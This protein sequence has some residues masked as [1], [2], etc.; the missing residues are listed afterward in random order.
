MADIGKLL[1]K[2]APRDI[3]IITEEIIELKQTAGAAVLGIGQR[4]NEAK[5]VLNHGEWLPWLTEKVEFSERSA[6]TFMRLAREWSNPQA[7]ADLGKSKALTLLALP[8][9]E[10]EQFIAEP[11]LVDGTVKN[12][13]DMTSRELEKAIR[14]RKEA[15]A[16]KEAAE[17][18][19][20]AANKAVAD[21]K[22]QLEKLK[23]APAEVAAAP[24]NKDMENFEVWMQQAKE[25]VNKMAGLLIKLRGRGD[26][27]DAAAV[28]TAMLSLSSTI[29]RATY[30]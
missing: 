23:A 4:L 24:A 26:H 12:V 9:D 22:A 7:L 5:A 27:V 13:V 16:A 17:A 11:H 20:N 15:L 21:L 14:E 2:Q 19:R 28:E 8:A 10:R 25:I 6:Q 18:E 29:G 30:G 1:A 3:G